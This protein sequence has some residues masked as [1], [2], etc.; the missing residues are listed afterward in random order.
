MKMNL[1]YPLQSTYNI[2][3]FVLFT[4]GLVFLNGMENS[5]GHF[6]DVWKADVLFTQN[7]VFVRAPNEC[8]GVP[9]V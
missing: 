5:E 1:R 4:E 7:E 8:Y 6:C 3:L 9:F 2:V